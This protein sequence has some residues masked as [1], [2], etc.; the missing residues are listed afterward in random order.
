MNFRLQDEANVYFER[1]L[2]WSTVFLFSFDFTQ[3]LP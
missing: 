3:A 1:R 2:G